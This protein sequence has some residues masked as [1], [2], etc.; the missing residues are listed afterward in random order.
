MVRL[1]AARY[2]AEYRVWVKFQDGLEGIVDLSGELYGEV[3]EPLRDLAVFRQFR[4]DPD[5][6]TITWSTGA[7][8]APDYLY[9]L[10][11]AAAQKPL[12]P[13]GSAGG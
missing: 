10:V 3:F 2:E 4:L 7:D 6:H 1:I 5:I 8:L 11:R 13:T 12:Q 9:D